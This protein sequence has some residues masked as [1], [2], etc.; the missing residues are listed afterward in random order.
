MCTTLINDC[1][2][3]LHIPQSKQPH[4]TTKQPQ[5]IGLNATPKGTLCPPN[6]SPQSNKC[7]MHARNF[8]RTHMHTCKLMHDTCQ[9]ATVQLAL[10]M[11]VVKPIAGCP[12][13]S[14]MDL[15][16]HHHG[17]RRGIAHD[18]GPYIQLRSRQIFSCG[19]AKDSHKPK[20]VRTLHNYYK[21]N[22]HGKM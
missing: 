5:A 18:V 7:H 19:R 4:N 2:R 1:P 22:D 8:A 21:N 17:T 15:A 16:G 9:P 20:L 3:W 13:A 6:Q 11:L 12:N 10:S 14:S